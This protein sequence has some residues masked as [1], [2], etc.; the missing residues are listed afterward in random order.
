MHTIG[1]DAHN[2]EGE[3]AGVGR[4]LENLLREWSL[5]PDIKNKARFILYYKDSVAQDEFLQNPIFAQKS[6]RFFKKVF[7]RASFFLYFLIFLPWQAWRDRVDLLFFPGYMVPW[8]Y[9]RP[10]VLVSHDI[11]FERFPHLFSWRSR[12][13]YR[14]FG[15][16]GAKMARAIITVSNFSRK[17]ILEL[18]HAPAGKVFAI[19]NGRDPRFA[20]K[21]DAQIK[22]AKEKLGISGDFIFFYGQIFNRRHVPELML[23][24]EKIAPHF[25][26]LQLLIV[27]RNKTDKPFIPIDK[28]AEGINIRL[29]RQ[30]VL[31]RQYIEKTE[32]LVALVSGAKAGAYLSDYEG[33]GLPPLEFLA[34][35]T[36]VLAPNST[37]LADTLG[38]KQVIIK[39]PYNVSEIAEALQETLQNPDIAK[40]ALAEGPA[41]AAKF[42]WGKCAAE[43]LNI[44]LASAKNPPH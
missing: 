37:A 16:Y 41:Q 32:D 34:C 11:S 40:R 2:L 17:E 36:P 23:A 1:I 20:R 26:E 24:F 27:G 22:E 6:L 31:L 10:A 5:S 30:A 42:S 39:D 25:P 3:R 18:Y 7:P 21:T 13:P 44:L 19:A 33:F 35:G 4:Y 15:R 38:G 12:I 14:I 43:T 28:I 9:R 8:T 29:K